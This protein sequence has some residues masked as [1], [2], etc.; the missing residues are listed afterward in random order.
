M[1]RFGHFALLDLSR[2]MSGETEK[3]M[4]KRH[5]AGVDVELPFIQINAV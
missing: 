1:D 4:E 5:C 3:E 2:R